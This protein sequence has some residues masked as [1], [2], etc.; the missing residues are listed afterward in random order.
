MISIAKISGQIQGISMDE[1]QA[2]IL[3]YLRFSVKPLQNQNIC[4]IITTVDYFTY[5]VNF[6]FL[7]IGFVALRFIE[8]RIFLI[9]SYRV[10]PMKKCLADFNNDSLIKVRIEC[11]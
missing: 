3:K 9:S 7:N 1:D 5:I 4:A 2:L 8:V 6:I 10:K 11:N